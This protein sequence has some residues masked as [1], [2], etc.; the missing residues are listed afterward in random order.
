MLWKLLFF[1]N[2]WFQCLSHVTNIHDNVLSPCQHQELQQEEDEIWLEPE[3]KPHVRLQQIVL[4]K[5]LVK[6]AGKYVKNRYSNCRILHS[7]S[8]SFNDLKHLVSMPISFHRKKWRCCDPACLFLQTHWRPWSVPQ[9]PFDVCK[10]KIWLRV[11]ILDLRMWMSLQVALAV[12]FISFPSFITIV[13]G[14]C[15]SLCQPFTWID[16]PRLSVLK[17]SCHLGSFA[18]MINWS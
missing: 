2:T 13:V 16:E 14:K 15:S 18:R 3:S 17:P 4:D 10:Q 9:P 1:Q 5:K 7:S 12:V 11:S 6:N 8:L